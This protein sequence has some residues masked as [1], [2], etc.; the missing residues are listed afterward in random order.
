MRNLKKWM[1]AVILI[2]GTTTMLTSCSDKDDNP[3]PKEFKSEVDYSDKNNW[4]RQPVA[5]KDV[6]AFLS[7]PRNMTT[8]LRAHRNLPP[9][10]SLP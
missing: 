1:L 4:M 3:A 6:D 2:S 7:I 5:T 8:P 9:S 10:M